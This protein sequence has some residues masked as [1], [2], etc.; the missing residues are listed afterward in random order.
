MFFEDDIEVAPDYFKY[1]LLCLR[2][3]VFGSN[4][5]RIHTYL[6]DHLIGVSLNTPRFHETGLNPQDWTPQSV[7]GATPQ[8]LFQLP[9]SWGAL[10]FPWAWNEFLQYYTWRDETIARANVSETI[11][12][13]SVNTW[14]RSWKRFLIELVYLKG[15]LMIYPNLPKQH[16]FSTH[17]REPGEHT[18]ADAE[19]NLVDELGT[20]ILDYFTVPLAT[21]TPMVNALFGDMQPLRKLPIVNFHHKL[22]QDVHELKQYALFTAEALKPFGF[23]Q[24][25]SET[26]CILDKISRPHM[27]PESNSEKY[28]FYLPQGS[29]SMQ[30]QELQTSIAM[31]KILQRT[32]IVPPYWWQSKNKSL[33][34]DT[35]LLLK[36]FQSGIDDTKDAWVRVKMWTQVSPETVWIDRLVDMRPWQLT[37]NVTIAPT[38]AFM[39]EQGIIPLRNVVVPTLPHQEF[40]LKRYFGTCQDKYLAFKSLWGLVLLHDNPARELEYQK[41][42]LKNMLLTKALTDFYDNMRLQLPK[43]YGCVAFSRGELPEL[44]GATQTDMADIPAK[45][46]VFRNC[47]ASVLRTSQYLLEYS[48]KANVTLEQIMLVYDKGMIATTPK[49]TRRPQDGGI[50]Y[51][52]TTFWLVQKATEIWKGFPIA[53]HAHMDEIARTTENRLCTEASLYVGN[54]YAYQS[55]YIHRKRRALG[56][57]SYLLGVGDLEFSGLLS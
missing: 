53:L 27:D 50:L 22:V 31:A 44:C 43:S 18:N 30:L 48:L 21:E 19:N 32:L 9:C 39:N 45:K 8:F 17:H 46:I 4:G 1:V 36:G 49:T 41:W 51:F 38:T 52:A 55:R 3:Y 5:R 26:G 35:M 10:Y 42:I 16:S 23:L 13:S 25:R 20:Q 24:D 34:I 57:P 33:N 29:L 12:F 11:P 37:A 54:L 14:V 47:F 56:R 28:L 6:H 7:V 40:E 2:K 15:Y